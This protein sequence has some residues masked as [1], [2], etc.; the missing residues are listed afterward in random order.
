MAKQHVECGAKIGEIVHLN[1]FYV[2][3]NRKIRR[4]YASTD[5]QHHL[6]RQQ[7]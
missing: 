7:N 5:K 1:G 4:H 3:Q 2:I 6:Y